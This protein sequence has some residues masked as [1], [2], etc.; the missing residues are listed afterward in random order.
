MAVIHADPATPDVPGLVR[1][2]AGKLP[3]AHLT[4][5]LMG[6][7]GDV[8]LYADACFSG[9]LCGVAFDAS[10]RFV[11]DLSQACRPIGPPHEIGAVDENLL[12]K[13]DGRPALAVYR[14]A[15]G[16]LLAANL[17]RAV[18]D[19]MVGLVNDDPARYVVRH[20][21]GIDSPGGRIAIND[22]PEEGQKILFVRRDA[23]AATY[24]L[25]R[26]LERLHA[27]CPHPQ[28]A[29]YISCAGRGAQLFKRDD[30]EIEAIQTVFGGIPLAGFFAGG[31]ILASELYAYTGVLTLFA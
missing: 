9:G 1:D 25:Q 21:I 19:V 5:G 30:S 2:M 22:L 3:A 29:L 4:G 18:D 12:S 20:V 27:Q 7:R 23:S 13:L 14:D 11:S 8:V 6:G 10:V 15:V 24:D 16:P 26:M 17:Q 31:E 28:A